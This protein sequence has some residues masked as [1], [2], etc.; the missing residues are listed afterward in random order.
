MEDIHEKSHGIRY[1]CI[2]ESDDVFYWEKK[3]RN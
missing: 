3:S 1:T 2:E